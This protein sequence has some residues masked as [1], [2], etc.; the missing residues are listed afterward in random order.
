MR[1]ENFEEI[2]Q[3]LS[4][5]YL[6]TAD[7]HLV[8]G[9]LQKARS[10][11]NECKRWE[12]DNS[13]KERMTKIEIQLLLAEGYPILA[14]QKLQQQLKDNPTSPLLKQWKLEIY[15]LLGWNLGS[16]LGTLY[17]SISEHSSKLK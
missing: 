4:E 11:L 9:D 6:I 3:Y 2:A 5:V 13:E 7:I 17:Q 15:Q 16:K 14:A 12:Q 10:F 1:R 8:L